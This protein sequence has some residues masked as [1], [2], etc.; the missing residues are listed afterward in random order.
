[1][2]DMKLVNTA[3]HQVRQELCE[4][5]L[6]ADGQYLD[7]IE[8]IVHPIPSLGEAGFVFDEGVPWYGKI[9]GYDE[10]VIYL[11]SNTPHQL[12]V[13]GG[14]L[15]DTIRHEFAHAWFWRDPEFI[16]Q[17]WFT[18]TFG[19]PYIN[20]WE[21]GYK[22]YKLFRSYPDEWEGSPYFM[23]FVSD[24]AISAPCEDFAE[25]FMTCLRYRN[26]LD[27]FRSRPGVF[28]KVTA[29]RKAIDQTAQKLGL[30]A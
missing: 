19:M 18:R 4:V 6:L 14:T 16:S 9:F 26:S 28:K 8:L 15:V 2:T 5:G 20:K 22:A 13:P 23:D 3:F 11:P 27:R 24:Y 30:V 1:M 17:P 29:V 12:Y 10:G 21:F 25:T 7:A